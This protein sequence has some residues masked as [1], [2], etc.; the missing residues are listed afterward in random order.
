MHV[1]GRRSEE[2]WREEQRRYY[3]RIWAKEDMRVIRVN[4]RRRGKKGGGK[5]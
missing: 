5:E 1:E 4:R 3:V 2:C